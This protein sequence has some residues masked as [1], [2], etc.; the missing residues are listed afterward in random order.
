MAAADSAPPGPGP[1]DRSGGAIPSAAIDG[2]VVSMLLRLEP[3]PRRGGGTG[4][5][6]EPWLMRFAYEGVCGRVGRESGVRKLAS[7]ETERTSRDGRPSALLVARR[8]GGG[9]G[10]LDADVD[11][12]MDVGFDN[13]GLMGPSYSLSTEWREEL[14]LVKIG[15]AGGL[16]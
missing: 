16:C 2:R 14:L 5:G 10:G 9:G 4:G 11:V 7:S 13:G 15:F 3:L 12:D 8:E 1:P 6:V